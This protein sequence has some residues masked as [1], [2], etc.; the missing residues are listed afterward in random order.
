MLLTYGLPIVGAIALFAAGVFVARFTS[1]AAS[2]WIQSHESIDP[3]LAP[4]AKNVIWATVVLIATLAAL[5]TVGVK[6]AS[7]LAVLGAAGLAIGLALK[8]SLGHV[9]SGIALLVVRPFRVGQHVKINGAQGVIREIGLFASKV[10]AWDG[11][12]IVVPNSLVWS[13]NITNFD[14]RGSR[15]IDLTF[16]IA[17]DDDMDHALQIVREEVV[18]EERI[19]ED[20]EPLVA[21]S[22]LGD[23]SVNIVARPWTRP[24]DWL[25]VQFTLTKRVKE[26]FDAEGISIPFPQRD[27][28]II[29]DHALAQAAE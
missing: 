21:V 14:S 8:D 1:G 11:E 3:T 7:L 26:R 9:A 15:R 28:H 19:L 23:S 12:E 20:P 27:L 13:Q 24:A 18:R 17:Y 16:G 2:R 25:A 6:L 5:Q 22:G 29:A 4:F 10:D